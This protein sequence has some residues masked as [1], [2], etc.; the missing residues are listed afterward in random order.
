MLP[1]CRNCT[2]GAVPVHIVPDIMPAA[3]GHIVDSMVLIAPL[4]HHL[5]PVARQPMA[6]DLA[7]LVVPL[8]EVQPGQ[9]RRGRW[10][11]IG[12]AFTATPP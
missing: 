2:V 6:D 9:E 12:V 5:E 8:K 4:L 1:T 3:S 7:Q 11:H 10:P